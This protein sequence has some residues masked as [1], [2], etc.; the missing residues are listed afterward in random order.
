MI[1]KRFKNYLVSKFHP[2]KEVRRVYRFG[3]NDI[4]TCKE[5]MRVCAKA[6]E[7]VMTVSETLHYVLENKVSMTRFGDGEFDCMFGKGIRYQ[8]AS[9]SLAARLKEVFSSQNKNLLVCTWRYD[10]SKEIAAYKDHHDFDF[11]DKYFAYRGQEVA[12]LASSQRYGDSLVSRTDSFKA[13]ELNTIRQLWANRNLVVVT[14]K[15]S[16]FDLD[17]RLFD[18]IKSISFVY[19]K[20]QNA[21][22]E[23]NDLLKKCCEKP[24][25][26]LFLISLGPTAT[27]LAHDL[28]LQGYQALDMGHI[29]NSYHEFLGEK[30]SPEEERKAES[31]IK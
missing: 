21:F 5:N 19:G 26:A 28:T 22:D 24:K 6:F 16:A 23:Y 12:S 29:T 7:N 11:Y 25:D 1:L 31:A 14:G 9:K 8:K 27:V 4:E 20:A 3:F 30:G 10:K 18:Q 15:D 17:S 13:G 2:S